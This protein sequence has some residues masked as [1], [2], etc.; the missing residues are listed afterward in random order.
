ME[1]KRVGRARKHL[2]GSQRVKDWRL[3]H[4]REYHR[5]EVLLREDDV[6]RMEA[7]ARSENRHTLE[8]RIEVDDA[9]LGGEHTGDPRILGTGIPGA[10]EH[11]HIGFFWPA[12]PPFPCWLFTHGKNG[13][14]KTQGS[15]PVSLGH[16]DS[17]KI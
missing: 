13:K 14:P 2:T 7:M 5:T 15:S 17:K 3:R 16:Y 4:L 11:R 12:L 9:Y 8:G 1:E 6:V 10:G